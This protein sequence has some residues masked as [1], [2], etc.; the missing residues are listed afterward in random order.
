[1]IGWYCAGSDEKATEPD[2]FGCVQLPDPSACF[3]KSKR[4]YNSTE[5]AKLISQLRSQKLQSEVW[6]QEIKECF[7]QPLNTITPYLFGS[8]MLDIRMGVGDAMRNVLKELTGSS[9]IDLIVDDQWD[10]KLP[11]E[12]NRDWVM[13][14][15]CKKWRRVAWFVD[16][17]TLSD[18]WMCASKFWDPFGASCDVPEDE[19]DCNEEY[20]FLEGDD[21]RVG[22]WKDVYCALTKKFYEAKIIDS[23]PGKTPDSV[24]QILMHFKGWHSKFDEWIPQDSIRIMSHGTQTWD[25]K[26][27]KQQE[28]KAME[29]R[30]QIKKGELSQAITMK[31]N[32]DNRKKISGKESKTTVRSDKRTSIQKKLSHGIRDKNK[33]SAKNG[34]VSNKKRKL[35]TTRTADDREGK[36]KRVAS[37]KLAD[38]VK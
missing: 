13:C 23:K 10:R 21:F 25:K 27:I 1:M 15:R 9:E 28:L 36:R 32:K 2:L 29:N 22:Q 6:P 8:P 4:T 34:K 30:N 24:P 11:P 5:R 31:E 33:M 14:D 16:V 35:N 19:F 7:S 20:D 37:T 18:P 3:G 38:F 17:N 26:K 12:S